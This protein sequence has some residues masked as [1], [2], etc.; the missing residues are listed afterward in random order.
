MDTALLVAGISAAV[1]VASAALSR[2]TQLK[3]TKLTTER[4][5]QSKEEERRS[6]AKVTLDKYRGPLLDAAWG[7]GNRLDNIRHLGFLAYHSRGS[8]RKEDAKLTTL[9]RVANYFGWREL[10]RMQVQLLR[11]ENEEDTKLVAG[12]LGDIAAVFASDRLD[13]G[14]AMLWGDEQRGI[15]ELMIEYRSDG[16]PFVRGHAAFRREYQD[17]FAPGMERLARDLLSPAAVRA[18]RLRLLQSAL[19]GLVQRLDEEGTFVG[20]WM[21]RSAD[22][23]NKLEPQEYATDSQLVKRLTKHLAALKT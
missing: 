21:V 15:G 5:K 18:D 10:V 14:R 19:F 8:D 11:F 12:F 17:I 4:E 22:E 13:A 3:V 20:G 9:F 23:I 1:A 7:L 6:A 2:S 16:S